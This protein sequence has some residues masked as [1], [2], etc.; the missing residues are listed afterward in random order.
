MSFPQQALPRI[1]AIHI[2][3]SSL[4][5]EDNLISEAARDGYFILIQLMF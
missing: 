3:Q 2:P 1:L 5:Q 4:N